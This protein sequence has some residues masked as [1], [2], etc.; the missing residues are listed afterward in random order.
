MNMLVSTAAT[1]AALP[2]ASPS[3][4]ASSPDA[5]PIF[6]ALDAWRRAELAL[7]QMCDVYPREGTASDMERVL[8]RNSLAQDAVMRT[9][10]TTPA[11]LA[12]LT[13]WMREEAE[14]MHMNESHWYSKD[15][16]AIAATLDDAVRGMSKLQPWSPP[17][18]SVARQSDPVFAALE[19]C[20]AKQTESDARYARVRA[21]YRKAAKDGLGDESELTARNAFVEA[22]IGRD[23]DE[24]T[25]E[26]ATVWWKAVDDL[27]D[28]NPTTLAGMAALLRYADNLADKNADLVESNA[29]KLVRT[30]LV[31]TFNLSKAARRSV[32]TA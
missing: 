24:Y 30:L 9:R 5:D 6:A 31:A 22:E 2:I 26:A 16:C 12:A 19:D 21:A 3:I 20:T 15:L 7:D 27:F 10:P 1:A 4:A 29:V 8:D 28:T 25:D 14:D 17:L 32:Q 13:N 11:G 18:P 23:P